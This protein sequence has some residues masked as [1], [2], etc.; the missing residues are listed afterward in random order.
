MKTKDRFI[1]ECEDDEFTIF[2]MKDGGIDIEKESPYEIVVEYCFKGDYHYDAYYTE[3]QA[4]IE[5]QKHCDRLNA[6][7][8][9]T[10]TLNTL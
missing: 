2:F 8:N 6:E 4:R 3:E 5:A 1:L 9:N 10:L 7:Y